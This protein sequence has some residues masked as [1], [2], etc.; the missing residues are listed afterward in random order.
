MRLW[1]SKSS[2]VPLHEQLTTQIMLGI[3]SHDLPPGERLPSTRGLARRFHIH[4]NTVSA[5][6]RELAERGWVEHRR[7]SGIYV[8][9]FATD[10]AAPDAQLELDQLISSFLNE[11]RTR[12]YT[13]K[14]IQ[15]RVVQWLALQPPDHLVVI[16]PD[17]ELRRILVRELEAATGCVV[18]GRS[19]DECSPEKEGAGALTG[20]VVVSMYGQAERVQATLPVGTT[21]LLLRA[22]SVVEAIEGQERPPVD[23]LIAAVSHCSGFLQWTRTMLVAAGIDSEA[24][25]FRD[26]REHGWQKG[27]AASAFVI[28]DAVTAGELPAG[29]RARVFRIIADASIAEVRRFVE[30]F[31]TPTAS[32]ASLPV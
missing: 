18:V 17:Q 24:L 4:P 8:R 7:G 16:E 22:R 19:I 21:C 9:P 23:R 29:C 6:Y 15:Q 12:G 25:D 32:P 11:A 5:A 31:F 20:G 2:E 30:Q 3:L 10:A 26:A 1:L 14:Q 28:T 13:L 27:L